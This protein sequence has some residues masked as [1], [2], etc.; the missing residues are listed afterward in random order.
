MFHVDSN[1]GITTATGIGDAVNPPLGGALSEALLREAGSSR[2]GD[3]GRLAVVVV[4][5]GRMG[6]EHA[7]A[8]LS[9]GD[10]VVAFLD[11]DISRAKLAAQELGGEAVAVRADIAAA[12]ERFARVDGGA[13]LVA[14]PSALHLPHAKQRCLWG[15]QCSWRNHRG[16]RVRTPERS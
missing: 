16:S 12:L 1:T 6:R 14:S 9:L 2:G 11:T 8:I 3:S 15:S 5:A 4:G 10:A 13:V 7:E